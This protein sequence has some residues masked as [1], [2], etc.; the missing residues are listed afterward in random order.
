V[1]DL[2]GDTLQFS[3][4][5]DVQGGFKLKIEAVPYP[6]GA[7]EFHPDQLGYGSDEQAP[8]DNSPLKT[9]MPSVFGIAMQWV[10]ISAQISI[11]I[12]LFL[13]DRK[14]HAYGS[15]F[16]D[17]DVLISC[18]KYIIS[19]VE[20]YK[21]NQLAVY[22]D[23]PSSSGNSAMNRKSLRYGTYDQK[24]TLMKA[25]PS[26]FIALF[27]LFLIFFAVRF[28]LI[29]N[30]HFPN[31]YDLPAQA[32]NLART[33]HIYGVTRIPGEPI[34]DMGQA[35]LYH[36]ILAPL[37]HLTEIQDGVRYGK[38]IQLDWKHVLTDSDFLVYCK[39]LSS[40]AGFWVLCL[41]YFESS[42]SLEPSVS[43]L[44]A[45]A[46]IVQPV[47][48][49]M[50]TAW[51]EDIQSLALGYTALVLSRRK[52]EWW[53]SA[54]LATLA[55][56]C[57]F[58][59]AVF[60]IGAAL[61][62]AAVEPTFKR[63]LLVFTRYGVFV[64]LFTMIFYTPAFFHFNMDL[65]LQF[66]DPMYGTT[67]PQRIKTGFLLFR[68]NFPIWIIVAAFL[69][70]EYGHR[71]TSKDRK[72]VNP[73]DGLIVAVLL[74]VL[75]DFH[76][77]LPALALIVMA[78]ALALGTLWKFYGP[79]F[80]IAPEDWGDVAV[81]GVIALFI[82][83]SPYSSSYYLLLIPSLFY[84]MSKRFHTKGFW[85]LTMLLSFVPMFHFVIYDFGKP[86]IHVYRDGY[87]GVLLSDEPRWNDIN[88]FGYKNQ[89]PLITLGR[90]GG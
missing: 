10:S 13:S 5:A 29:F 39:L 68:N 7:R 18:H 1:T 86:A 17:I 77:T 24:E 23:S 14:R 51:S 34:F 55:T 16:H 90:K 76:T 30:R 64:T 37:C 87:Y 80:R 2:L 60:A 26:R 43:Y 78:G 15:A 49:W 69:L 40:L 32:I 89:K 11:L 46:F 20:Y 70:W 88:D 81:T 4:F 72:P 31:D 47:L 62:Y 3:R 25:S 65:G 52:W 58:T 53:S 21:I 73:W 42:N 56:G 9:I 79:A 44:V 41:L 50:S 84:L 83:L 35:I 6:S 54:V 59:A 66:G 71:W 19:T 67:F 63:R 22:V 28:P 61:N 45:A 36:K 12:H 74:C 8:I 27:S 48:M 57:K 82:M 33:Q 38:I 85:V 75:A